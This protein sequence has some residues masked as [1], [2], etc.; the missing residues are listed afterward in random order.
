MNAIVAKQS[1]CQ[2][3]RYLACAGARSGPRPFARSYSVVNHDRPFRLAVIGSGPAGFYTA[4]RVKSRIQN[5]K[6]D[7][8]EALPVPFGLVRFGVAPDHP[9]V[10][11]SIART[12][13]EKKYSGVACVSNTEAI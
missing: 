8:Y 2:G 10:K 5:T 13:I 3:C 6:V 11:V 1:L 12:R 7:M 9:E 4:Y